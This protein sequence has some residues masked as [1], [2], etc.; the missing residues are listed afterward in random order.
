MTSLGTPTRKVAAQPDGTMLAEL[1]AEPMQV[2]RG[3]SWTPVDPALAVNADRTISPK[4][5]VTGTTLS[6]GGT[7]PLLKYGPITL[8]WPDALPAP[9][10]AG[11]TATYRD[12]LPGV[13]LE[14]TAA[15]DHVTQ[16]LV[17]KTPEAAKNPALARVELGIQADGVK[18]TVEDGA[19][20]ATDADGKV[21]FGTP[22]AVMWD[23][24]EE[25]TAPVGLELHDTS[26]TL[27]PD[28]ALL[29]DPGTVFPVTIDPDWRT[30]DIAGWAKVFSGKP[31]SKHWW[32]GGDVDSYAK[33]GRCS[34]L[35]GCTG[36]NDIGA[37]RSFWEFDTSFLNGK[38]VID[39]SLNATILYSPRCADAQHELWIANSTFDANLT[40]NN[41]PG[42]TKVGSANAQP[43]YTGCAGNKGIG[44]KLG[45]YYNPSGWS[46]Y[47]IR[48]GNENS[49][50]TD[51][52]R[53]YDGG[54]TRIVA[55]YNTKPDAA[56]DLTTEP[57]GVVCKWCAGKAYLTGDAVRLKGRITDG[58]G[59]DQLT[60]NWSIVA[61]GRPESRTG[62]Q[63]QQGNTY[64]TTYDLTTHNGQEVTWSLRGDDGWDTGDSR[65]GP[66]FVVD[67]D[68]PNAPPVVEAGLYQDDNRWHGGVGVPG[69]FTFKAG[70][71]TDVDHY[72]YR[73]D[74]QKSETVDADALGGKATVTTTPPGD[75]PRALHVQ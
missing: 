45:G 1:S 21:L 47:F 65:G 49:G 17:V 10:L 55:Q 20:R 75:G 5:V 72:V 22:P 39:I 63:L 8:T 6:G 18:V 4:A 38:R 53:K 14:L 59:S 70:D 7:G 28:Q 74:E 24:K 66:G 12:V 71:V 35:T 15:A 67:R 41:Q 32:G 34:G 9:E 68:P 13:D 29:T 57:R 30:F 40:W 3:D 31:D 48:A 16:H 27:V 23:A 58:D 52:W 64:S 11:P 43:A 51:G 54:A 50:Y 2:R 42:G 60:A 73:W 61:G 33:V 46:A 19:L 25:R 36:S 44:W 26:L 56:T 37:T 69:A 62:P